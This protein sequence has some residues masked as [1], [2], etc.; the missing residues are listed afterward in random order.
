MWTLWLFASID[1]TT[2]LSEKPRV[3]FIYFTIDKSTFPVRAGCFDPTYRNFVLANYDA[4]VGLDVIVPI[5]LEKGVGFDLTDF[6]PLFWVQIKNSFKQIS[7]LC[8]EM[9]RFLKLAAQ[10]FVVNL[11]ST[12]G[13]KRQPSAEECVQ[14]YSAGPGVHIYAIIQFPRNHLWGSIAWTPASC[15][16][17]LAF[18]VDITESEIHDFHSVLVIQQEIFRLE[19][20]VDY[21]KFVDV[22]N[23]KNNLDKYFRALLFRNSILLCDVV[24]K[25]AIHGIIHHYEEMLRGLDDLRSQDDTF[26]LILLFLTSYKSTI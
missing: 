6:D 4:E 5:L 7:C 17:L 16:E 14:D 21:P 25:F 10:D 15:L 24:I 12:F 20:S 18:P 19:V 22:L 9:V 23:S 13:F 1:L 11:H 3:S 8:A 2:S 26:G